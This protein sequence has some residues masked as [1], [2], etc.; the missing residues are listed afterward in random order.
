MRWR[1]AIWIGACLILGGCAGPR[2]ARH[3]VRSAELLRPC[4]HVARSLPLL[5]YRPP[6]YDDPARSDE[7]W[8]LVLHLHGILAEGS[9]RDSVTRD[10]LP[11][12][13]EQGFSPP[14]IVVSPQLWT[15]A[16]TWEREVVTA[17]LEEVLEEYRVDPDRVILMGLSAGATTGWTVV[18]ERPDLFAGFVPVAGW[19]TPGGVERAIDVPIWAV[20]GGL[21]FTAPAF[22][23]ARG[24]SAHHALGGA[25]R[26]T[27]LKGVS[28]WI[29]RRV[30]QWPAL[31]DWI[32]DQRRAP[33][34]TR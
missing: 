11:R 13:L 10:G 3:D 14:C 18:K 26:V 24:V 17:A 28:H 6:G 22:A 8:P 20:Y 30:W 15:F 27:I 25:T 32:L 1:T 19:I 7:R 2:V 12:L 31:W 21:D 16:Q 5:V 9:D 29:P 34:P 33:R 23:A 4:G